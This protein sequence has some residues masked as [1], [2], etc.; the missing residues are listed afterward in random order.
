MS[1]S[2]PS[3]LPAVIAIIGA[4]LIVT[5]LVRAMQRYTAPEPLNAGRAVERVKNLKEIQAAGQDQVASYAKLPK[6][7]IRLPVT[8][9]MTLTVKEYA[10]PVAARSNLLARAAKAFAAVP[11]PKNEFE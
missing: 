7:F 1:D 2:K 9:A 10:N 8:N 5:F 6:D 3:S 11:P 4:L